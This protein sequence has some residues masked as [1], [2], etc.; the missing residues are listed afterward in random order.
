MSTLTGKGGQLGTGVNV[1]TY[2]RIRNAYLDAQYRTQNSALSGSATQAEELQQAQAAFNEPSSSGIASQLSDVLERVEQPRELAHQR[3]RQAGRGGRGRTAG[4]H[5]QTAERPAR[6]RSPR[7]PAS[8][9]RRCTGPTGEVQDYANQIA[10][11]NGQI[12]L[13]EE[14]GQKPNDMLDRRDLLL[15]K[16]SSLAQVTVTQQTEWHRHRELRRRDRTADRRHHRQ[17]AADPHRGRGRTARR[18][19]RAHRPRRARSPTTRPRSTAWSTTSR[20]SV[21]AL[22]TSTPFFTRHDRRHARRRGHTRKKSRPPPRKRAGGND[23]AQAI[24]ALRGGNADQSYSALIER[25]GSDV[26]TAQDEQSNDQTTVTAIGNQRH[27][28]LRRVAG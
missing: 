10:Q 13:A 21:N 9:T 26:K 17:L 22:H 19:A 28:R 14:A 27:E 24:A 1:E 23:V 5:V 18:T 11:L 2:T 12:K 4:E 6:Q 25:V 20:A 3:S 16:L 7:R 15:D 8:S